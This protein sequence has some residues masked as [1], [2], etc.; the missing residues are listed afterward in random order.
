[1]RN[2]FRWLSLGVTRKDLRGVTKFAGGGGGGGIQGRTGRVT[3][4][5]E[6]VRFEG[7]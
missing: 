5:A 1:M 3:R 2:Y 6:S 4:L 7:M